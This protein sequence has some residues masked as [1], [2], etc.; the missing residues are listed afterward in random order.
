M[1]YIGLFVHSRAASCKQS[2]QV[3]NFVT[4]TAHLLVNFSV[5]AGWCVL[6]PILFFRDIIVVITVVV[7]VFHLV[8]RFGVIFGPPC[9]LP[10]PLL[11][12][13]SFAL[14]S[15]RHCCRGR[16]QYY[17]FPLL[18]TTVS[19]FGYLRGRGLVGVNGARAVHVSMAV[20]PA[21]RESG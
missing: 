3:R 20:G 4:Q 16:S 12:L 1:I 18:A 19:I 8:P 11:P 7:V 9:W 13:V 6:S 2:F 10:L 15:F 21:C 17:V 14:T 5:V